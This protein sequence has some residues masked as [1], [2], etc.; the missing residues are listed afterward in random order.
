MSFFLGFYGDS[1][2]R[3]REEDVSETMYKDTIRLP[4]GLDQQSKPFDDIPKHKVNK[5]CDSFLDALKGRTS[6]QF[7]NVITAH[8]CKVPPD[9]DA[10]LSQIASL[11]SELSLRRS[12][13]CTL[14]CRRQKPGSYGFCDRAYM[15]LSR[16]QSAL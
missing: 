4:N 1:L 11:R 9:L 5:I 7:Q 2:S 8:V 6:T 16:R 13:N 12:N 3:D 14:N 10:G 15:L